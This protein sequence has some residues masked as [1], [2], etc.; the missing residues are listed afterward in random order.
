[1]AIIGNTEYFKGISE[2][3]YEGRESDNPLAF[4]YYNPD[5]VVAGKTMREH[6]K[7][8]VAYWHTFCGQGADPFGP[9][10]QNFK[11]DQSTDP[12]QAAK[13]KADAAFE[14]ISK[15]GFD[16]FCFH[17]YDLVAEASSF[18]ESEKRLATIT[19]YIKDKQAASGIKL[20]WGTANCF[21]NPRY[22]NG[23]ATNPEFNVVARAG[24]QVKLALDATIKLNGENYVFWGGREG[25]MSLLNTNMGRE[26][27]H[28]AQFLTMAK[29]YARSQ[30]FKG[31]FFI[32]PKP[33]EPSKHQYDFD[34]A[35]A[36][37]FLKEYGL[38]KDFKINIEVNHATLAQHTFQHE[39]EVAAKAGMLG[40]I[41]A[42]R[43][44]YQNGWDTDQFPNNIQET[45]EAMLV[46]LKAGGLQGGGVNFDAKIRRNST[47]IDDV[48]HA[49]IGG[50]DTFARALLTANKILT[51]S[52]YE[53][54]REERYSSFDS[55]NGKAFEEGKL[56]LTDL[57]KIAQENGE[58]PL[59][60]G[61]QELFE[62]II[63]QY[64]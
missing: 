42:N 55:G 48:F 61:K 52:P 62:N 30:G 25:Y 37:G 11:W 39:L 32:E 13:D 22:M 41:D 53:K 7:F 23:A 5:Q 45:T 21:S 64:I 26:L 2:I 4:K 12:I 19:D 33:M 47:D 54:L 20:L 3:Q 60:S 28:M 58:L 15:M 1:M 50:A 46:F 44:D 6:F 40:S 27:D 14:F 34:T 49:H 16:Y 8:A 17:D 57:Y 35:T 18:S 43:G 10:T 63:N 56:A 38:D 9:G 24:G 59:V 36:I 29:D 31:T 51:S